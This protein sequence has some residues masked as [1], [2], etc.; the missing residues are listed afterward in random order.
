MAGSG[1]GLT[2]TQALAVNGAKVYITG[3]TEEKLQTVVDRHGKG[4][5]GQIIPVTADVTDK[6]DIKRLVKD[7]ES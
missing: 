5:A 4:I 2:C 3:C 6:E 7:I 1:I